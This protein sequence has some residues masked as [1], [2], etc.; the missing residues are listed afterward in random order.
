MAGRG[1]QCAL[2][3]AAAVARARIAARAPP[4]EPA[5]R[6]RDEPLEEVCP[7]LAF[8]AALGAAAT[9]SGAWATGDVLPPGF[10][11]FWVLNGPI[12]AD[13]G[14]DLVMDED[15]NIFLG[16][17]TGRSGCQPRWC[18]WT[19]RPTAPMPCS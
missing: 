11:W 5:R 6:R 18:G 12:S 7:S 4:L 1:H 17:Y 19:S 10:Q 14:A 16:G 13:A 8:V 15:G 3:D 2:Q 9:S